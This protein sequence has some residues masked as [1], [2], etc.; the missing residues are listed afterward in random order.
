MIGKE[1]RKWVYVA[2]SMGLKRVTS[3]FPAFGTVMVA[4][5]SFGHSSIFI[6]GAAGCKFLRI[7]GAP[8][9]C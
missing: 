3:V 2:T 6:A 1:K 4:I 5:E 7:C 9:V 8:S